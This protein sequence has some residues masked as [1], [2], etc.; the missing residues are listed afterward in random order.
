MV[1][2][3]VFL[4]YYIREVIEFSTLFLLNQ[5]KPHTGGILQNSGQNPQTKAILLYVKLFSFVYQCPKNMLGKKN[6][7]NN[8]AEDMTSVFIRT[9]YRHS[10]F[11]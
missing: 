11:F 1:K 6:I 5:E 9:L 3:I 4:V 2:G 8:F 10:N 7:A